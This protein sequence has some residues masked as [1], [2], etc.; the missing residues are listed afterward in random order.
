MP[1][2]IDDASWPLVQVRWT[3][4]VTDDEVLLFQRAMD[5]WFARGAPF[6]LMIDSRGA[7][8]LTGEQRQSVLA[9]IKA[10]AREAELFLVNAFVVDS[11][12]QRAFYFGLAWAFAFP[13]PSKTFV[14][15][16]SAQQWLRAQIDAR[17]RR[18][19]AA[20]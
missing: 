3:G 9:H 20:G 16:E 17:T 19:E 6:G 4:T 2:H 14:D 12:V 13:F 15:P 5:R 18:P 1:V 8:S 11:A 10:T 7:A